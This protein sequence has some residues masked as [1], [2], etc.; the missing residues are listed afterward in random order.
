MVSHLEVCLPEKPPNP[1]SLGEG[2]TLPQSKYTRELYLWNM[3]RTKIPA[4]LWLP[5]QSNNS[6]KEQKYSFQSFFQV[7]RKVT[8]LI[9]ENLLQTTVQM[10]VLIFKVFLLI[11]PTLQWHM[12]TPS[13]S[14]L[15]SWICI[16]LLPIFWMSVMHFRIQMFPF[17]KES[18]S[19]HQNI[20]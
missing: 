3:K 7:L 1:N 13:E 6:L 4:F 16:D 11:S 15:L 8:V 19:F 2:L 9:N 10:G 14:T 18:V 20:I 17:T 12:L 5:P